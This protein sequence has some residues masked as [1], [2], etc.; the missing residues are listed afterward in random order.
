MRA[1][2][3]TWT[4]VL[5]LLDQGLLETDF[6]LT[7]ARVIFE[8][9]QRATWERQDLRD[10][11]RLDASFLTRVV[12]RLSNMGLVSSKPSKTDGRAVQLALTP[13]G[14]S[15]FDKLNERSI[16]QL[17]KFVQPLT[18]DQRRVLVESMMTVTALTRRDA[19]K[20]RVTFRGLKPGDLGWVVQR[21][22]AI[23]ADE[24]GWDTEFEAL[25]ARIVADYH[26]DLK[27]DRENA[28]IAEIGGVRAGCIFC[29]E[30]DKETAQLR[31][32]LVEPWARGLHIGRRLVDRCVTFSRDAGYS[33]LVLWTN[34]VLTAAR[35][36]YEIAGFQL[37]KEEGHHS[38]GQDLVGQNWSLNLSS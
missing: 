36:I 30:R 8:L 5:G 32:L 16:A 1:F 17:S 21:H 2:N 27:P 22:G 9:A 24:F 4:E 14:R 33:S 18:A 6:S 19:S 29:C 37:I 15:A 38:F 28:W 13:T 10:Q 7:E 35:R 31:I 12:S 26:T 11:L 20:K 3:R 25:V 23:Y 34:D